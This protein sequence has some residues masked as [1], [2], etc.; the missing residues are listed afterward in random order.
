MPVICTKHDIEAVHQSL[1]DR[2]SAVLYM[3]SEVTGQQ[4]RAP[5][6]AL[7]D[8]LQKGLTPSRE[9]DWALATAGRALQWTAYCRKSCYSQR[10]GAP[11]WE[12]CF[13]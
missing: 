8:V 12:I 10:G 13:L 2:N 7:G 11:V 6:L 3:P 5:L 9:M 1:L 4:L